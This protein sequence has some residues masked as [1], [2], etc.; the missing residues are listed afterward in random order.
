MRAAAEVEPVALFVDLD[1]L[2]CGDGVDELDLERLALVAEH[3]LGLVA[4]PFLLGEGF[5]ARDDLAHLLLDRVEVLR[6]ER[7]IAE[8]VV[9]EAVLD[10]R[11]D[12]DLRARPQALDG[13]GEHMG[14]VVPDELQRSRVVA[15]DEFDLGVALDRVTE[16]GEH[17]IE[18][19]G[20]GAL[21]ERGRDALGDIEPG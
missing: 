3:A 18:R 19:H 1:L 11:A 20:D 13:L 9:I 7:L 4:R 8:E 5:V 12:G 15:A 6:G 16:V 2:V 17:A 21:G 10:D 14:G